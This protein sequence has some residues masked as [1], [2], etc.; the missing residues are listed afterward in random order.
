MQRLTQITFISIL[1]IASHALAEP[2]GSGFTYQGELTHLGAPANGAFDFQFNLH[3]TVADGLPLTAPLVVHDVD[4][5]DGVFTVELDFGTEFFNG[6]Q[7][8]LEIAVREGASVGAFT[9]LDPRQK[10]TASP[11]SLGT[12]DQLALLQE[13]VTSLQ[14]QLTTLLAAF[15]EHSGNTD[16]H[17]ARYQDDEAITAVGPHYTDVQAIAAVGPHY[18]NADAIAAV[19]PHFSGSHADLNNVMP[20]QH[21]AD[22]GPGVT[23]L[24]NLLVDVSRLTDPNTGQDTL[25]FSDMNVQIVNG[26]GATNS[27]TGVGNLII[28][29]NDPR[30]DTEC[31]DGFEC[32]RRSGSHML[33]T[34][35]KN[36][37]SSWGGVVLGTHNE[38]SGPY[39]SVSGGILNQASG[40][41]AS[42][43]GGW[44]NTAS[45][46]Y[47]SVS[48]GANNIASGEMASVSGG[49]GN[50]A[51]GYLGS[52]SG[53]YGNQA[54]G[55]ESSV[56]GGS[57]NQAIGNYASILGGQSGAANNDH[58][59]VSGV[60][61]PFFAHAGESEAHHARYADAEAVTAVGPH[62]TDAQAI[63]A[64]GPHFSGDHA[65]LTNVTPEQHHIRYADAEAVAA[66]GPHY[67]DAQ[68]IAAVGPHFSGNHDDLSNVVPNQHHADQGPS[69]TD[70]ETLLVGVSRLTD[71]NTSQDT[72]QFSNMNVQIV[73]GT[74][75][76]GGTPRGTG[77][78][79]IGYNELRDESLASVPC[80]SDVDTEFWCNRRTGSHML[81][82]GYR[83]NYTSYG[84]IV[85]GFGNE[86]AGGY[87]SVSGGRDNISSGI[88]SYV[89]G[90]SDNTASANGSSVSGGGGNSASGEFASVS[91]GKLNIASGDSASVSGGF[92]KRANADYCIVGDNGV[93]C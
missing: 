83:A 60:E 72:L 52:V 27:A 38:T 4:V 86:T 57:Q 34:G 43:S 87:A 17:H 51:S 93:D 54:T 74:G 41:R 69:V 80:P 55:Q 37:Y 30:D 71:P 64:V 5:R 82:V 91:G 50:Q 45:G 36:N 56:S 19:G 79:I 65:A 31:P 39:A 24:E 77:N 35:W 61:E 59:T 25:Q 18:T 12:S 90:G 44:A 40:S 29:Y 23:E 49:S 63:A 88:F 3:D 2:L 75:S 33:V 6:T 13:E 70:L 46:D 16:A 48:G 42:V 7:L 28:G 73:D 62:Y 21:H 10:L 76:T 84:G 14:S 78:L 85:V 68:A 9:V 66:V 53:G 92:G 47:A 58:E 8:W 81:V 15:D 89:G 1:F 22:Q 32:N 67:T 26:T 20:D 11:Y